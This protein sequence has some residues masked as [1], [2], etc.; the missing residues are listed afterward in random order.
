MRSG[1]ATARKAV[2]SG[3]SSPTAHGAMSTS[4][5]LF[6]PP[7]KSKSKRKQ[8]RCWWMGE[9]TFGATSGAN[10]G[11]SAPS[12]T[13]ETPTMPVSFTSICKVPSK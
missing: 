7:S 11:R 3:L 12:A 5:T 8:N 13:A 1:R 2:P 9:A 4:L 10:S 6:G